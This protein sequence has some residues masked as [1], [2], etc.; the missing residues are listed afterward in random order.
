MAAEN[1]HREE[2]Q[3]VTEDVNVSEADNQPAYVNVEENVA[4]A[5][6]LAVVRYVPQND[7]HIQQTENVVQN[8]H[9]L[10]NEDL[11]Q[12]LVYPRNTWA[13]DITITVHCKLKFIDNIKRVL[14]DQGEL[15][16][17]KKGCFR[18]YLDIPKHM[19]ALFQGQYIHNLLLRQI[20]FSGASKDEIWFALG[21]NK[22]RLGKREFCLCTRLKFGVLPIFLR[23]YI[24]VPDRIHIRYFAGEGGLLLEEVLNRDIPAE[25]I[26]QN[27]SQTHI[28]LQML[29][30]QPIKVK[31]QTTLR[32]PPTPKQ[33]P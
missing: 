16:S 22:V 9:A 23:D 33:P 18:H 6:N 32:D 5:D 20:Q 30:R 17:F 21:K 31:M 24:P 19:R 14:E 28:H 10:D 27:T 7:E 4:E 3:N 12:Y 8:E 11:D 1:Q 15:A 2:D 25:K 29:S 13:Y 26:V